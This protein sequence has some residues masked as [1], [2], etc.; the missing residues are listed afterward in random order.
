[1]LIIFD[2]VTRFLNL[3]LQREVLSVNVVT[4][5]C[6][7]HTSRNSCRDAANG[8]RNLNEH[9]LEAHG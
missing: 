6:I 8:G 9:S 1:M 5:D 2:R 7:C 3:H 4:S